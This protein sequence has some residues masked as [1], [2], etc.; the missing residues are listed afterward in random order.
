MNARNV[1][2][3]GDWRTSTPLRYAGLMLETARIAEIAGEAARALLA[4]PD[5]ERVLTQPSTDSEGGE[6][7]RITLV[8]KPE[9]VRA[10]SGDTAL[11]LLVDIQQKL[12]RAGEERL[13]I[14]DY[15]TEQELEGDRV[16]DETDEPEDESEI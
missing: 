6:A 7:L 14:V 1:A 5:L 4:P 3:T 10:L 12:S 11:N 9:A 13:P 16:L 2:S 8:L 15:A